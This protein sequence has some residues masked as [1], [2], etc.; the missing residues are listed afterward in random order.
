MG[1]IIRT[2]L[3]RSVSRVRHVSPVRPS[4]ARGSVASVYA[5]VEADF[6]LLAPPVALHSPAPVALAACWALLRETLVAS[7]LATRA[8]KE[9][10][11][12]S[13]SRSNTCPYCV[14]VHGATLRELTEGRGLTDGTFAPVE[15]WADRSGPRPFPSEQVP[16]LLGVAVAFHY[17]NRMVN[18]FLDDSPL[19]PNAPAVAERFLGR[20]MGASARK[21]YPPG[22]SLR[23]LPA[24]P[25]PPDLVW[26][27]GNPV[28][29]DMF[30]RVAAAFDAGSRVLSGEARDVVLAHVAG[31]DGTPPGLGRGWAHETVAGLSPAD[32]P[33]ALLALL[34]ATASYQVDEGAVA[35]F[36]D[37]ELVELTSWAS[38]TA[39]RRMA[40]LTLRAT[41]V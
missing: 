21:E 6:G 12:A 28:V 17:L 16:E 14:T 2:A 15:A 13:V 22:T 10:V 31:W 27:A 29:G 20:F 8:V 26:A 25:L 9:A 34:V 32:R 38:F 3:R 30:G 39:A 35:G 33:G 37:A 40:D 5:E 41:E 4:A 24:A 1:R 7:G 19:P 23:R 36:G 18:V 11:A